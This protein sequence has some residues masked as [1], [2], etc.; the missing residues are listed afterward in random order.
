VVLPP[1]PQAFSSSDGM[2]TVDLIQEEAP[3][4]RGADG[5]DRF[6]VDS[7]KTTSHLGPDCP[8]SKTDGALSAG[9]AEASGKSQSLPREAAAVREPTGR[10]RSG[11]RHASMDE[12]LKHPGGATA[13]VSRLQE[14]IRHKLEET[15]R[16]L[17]E[18]QGEA[19]GEARERGRVKGKEATEAER[20]L[21][22]A[23]AT[24]NQAQKVLEEVKELRALCRQLDAPPPLSPA[25]PQ[26]VQQQH[27]TKPGPEEPHVSGL[28]LGP[29]SRPELVGLQATLLGS[30]PPPEELLDHELNQR[31]HGNLRG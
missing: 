13:S 3:P 5:R 21:R 9:T 27:Q 18:A 23:A 4:P 12:T 24:W 8:R 22:E 30:G 31:L 20:L 1:P 29:R 2:L 11:G 7:D 10:T 26:P 14:M 17:G 28:R 25:P 19:S 15:E 16:L 6:R